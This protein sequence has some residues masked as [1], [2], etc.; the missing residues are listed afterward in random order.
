MAKQINP[1]TESEK[2]LII[3]DDLVTKEIL[4]EILHDHGYN[5]IH[6]LNGADG[7]RLLD[8]HKPEII[9]LDIIMPG[10][11]GIEVCQS[12]RKK[13]LKIRPSI[14]MVSSNGDYDTVVKAFNNGADD[15]ITKPVNSKELIA[16]IQAQSRIRNFYCEIEKKNSELELIL[17]ITENASKSLDSRE[18][19]YYIVKKT[20]D[21]IGANRCSIVLIGKGDEAYVVASHDSPTI[22]GLKIDLKKYPELRAVLSTKES[23]IIDDMATHPLLKNVKNFVR[24]LTQNSLLIMPIVWEEE[25]L[26]TL[27]LRTRRSIKSFTSDEIKLCRIIANAAYH[28]LKKAKLFENLTTEKEYLKNLAIT[29]QLTALYNHD[30]FYN[31]LED[32][33]NRAVRYELPLSLLMI[34]LDNFKKINDT[35]GHR[36]GDRVLMEVAGILKKAVRKTDI[37]SRYGGEEFTVILPV[38]TTE[39]AKEEAERI[40]ETL[41]SHSYAGL[42][43][44][45]ISASIGVASYPCAGALNSGD[46]VN[47]ADNALYEAKNSGRNKVAVVGKLKTT[48]TRQP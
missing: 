24:S 44:T 1:S 20:A 9:L 18:I 15:F 13:S 40:R 30:F 31:R 12:I 16:R 2:V 19:L 29:D 34:D 21:F 32:E 43:N 11:N 5:T 47:L 48:Q 26:G 3:D 7:L 45:T 28:P 46:L 25:I 38:T 23:L 14:I 17:D 41:C 4:E 6:A 35:Y 33:F 42:I 36:A 8:A 27:I 39:G 22:R 10:M 37:V